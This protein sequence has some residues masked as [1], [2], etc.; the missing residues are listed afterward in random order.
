MKMHPIQ[1]VAYEN[2]ITD[3]MAQV[4]KWCLFQSPN[5]SKTGAM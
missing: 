5:R 1:L 4:I 2:R 3:D